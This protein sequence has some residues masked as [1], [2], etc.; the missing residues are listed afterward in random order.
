MQCIVPNPL[1]PL[2]AT[3]SGH[4]TDLAR[5]FELPPSEVELG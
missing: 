4:K 2:S 3:R 5:F 1:T